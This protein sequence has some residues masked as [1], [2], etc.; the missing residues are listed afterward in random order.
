MWIL[1][2]A[3]KNVNCLWCDLTQFPDVGEKGSK[4]KNVNYA[5]KVNEVEILPDPVVRGEPFTFK[6]AAYTGI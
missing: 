4:D 6:I 1:W 5:V 2:Y 3:D